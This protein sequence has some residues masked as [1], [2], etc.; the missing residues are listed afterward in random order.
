ML[1]TPVSQVYSWKQ[2]KEAHDEME[3]NKSE[4]RAV[5]FLPFPPHATPADTGKII[6]TID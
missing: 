5:S 3:S 1:L 6:V 2:I 4:C